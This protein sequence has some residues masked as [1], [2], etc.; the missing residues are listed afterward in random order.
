MVCVR[1]VGD[2]GCGGNVDDVAIAHLFAF[3]SVRLVVW[4]QA[5]GF[6]D[7]EAFT[8]ATFTGKASNGWNS[9][10]DI[11]EMEVFAVSGHP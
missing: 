5:A 7:G 4:L 6:G 2:V 11:V 1:A 10:I 3:E 8:S 9:N